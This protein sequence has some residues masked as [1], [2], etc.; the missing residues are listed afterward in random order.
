MLSIDA[1]VLL[2][3]LYAI[4]QVLLTGHLSARVRELENRVD[5]LEDPLAGARAR[6]RRRAAAAAADGRPPREDR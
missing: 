4:L 2:A 1:L 3:A 6:A 5:V